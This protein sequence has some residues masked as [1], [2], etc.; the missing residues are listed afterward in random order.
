[1]IM[2]RIVTLFF[3]LSIFVLSSCS[4]TDDEPDYYFIPLQVVSAELPQSFMLH[5]TYE[6]KVTYILPNG[7]ASFEGFDVTPIAQTT[8]NVVPIGSQFDDPDCVDGGAEVEGSFNFVC[9]Y[10]DTYLFRFW[11][12]ENESG[13]QEYL[14]FEVPVNQ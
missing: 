14:E 8:R 11:K 13:E 1:M 6:I 5:E 10:S 9:L 2:K 12:G 4:V 7:C 3:A